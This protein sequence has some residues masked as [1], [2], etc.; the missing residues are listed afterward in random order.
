VALILEI[1]DRRGHPTWHTLD[2]LPLSIGRGLSN[3]IIL[4]DPYADATHARVAADASGAL[5]VED[6]GSVNGLRHNGTRLAASVPV[7]AGT[8]LRIGRTTLRFRDREEPVPPAFAEGATYRVP[9]IVNWVLSTRGGGIVYWLLLLAVGFNTWLG[10][11][12]RSPGSTVFAAVVTVIALATVWSLIWAA[13]TRGPDRRF[14]LFPHF[15]VISAAGLV[16]LLVT[17]L[18]EWFD[19]L[20][21]DT[22]FFGILVSAVFLAVVAL[23]F[24]GHLTVAGASTWKGRWRVGL[25]MSAL[26]LIISLIA[27]AVSEDKFSDVAKFESQLE[28]LTP[29]L[30]PTTSVTQF[31][32][33]AADAKK[34]ADEAV[35]H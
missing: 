30:V 10:S 33:A 1:R 5:V 4:D 2:R 32:A 26:M 21:P 3:D 27:I 35:E 12:D 19:F 31:V 23:V 34:E 6:L 8:E 14:L 9:A 24:V 7:Q 22:K 18:N 20:F 17:V 15:G 28:P 29:A 11:Y 16:M 25:G 13:T